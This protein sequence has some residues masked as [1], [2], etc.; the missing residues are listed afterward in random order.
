MGKW[1]VH[2]TFNTPYNSD[3]AHVGFHIQVS[4][5]ARATYKHFQWVEFTQFRVCRHRW[6]WDNVIGKQTWFCDI[7]FRRLVGHYTLMSAQLAV[8]LRAQTSRIGQIPPFLY[9]YMIS[10]YSFAFS[11]SYSIAVWFV[12]CILKHYLIWL[13]WFW[14]FV[15]SLNQSQLLV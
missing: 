3:S 2:C 8:Q 15:V 6:P 11:T 10:L 14:F 13:I 7:L 9:S 1:Q 5:F 4:F 12:I